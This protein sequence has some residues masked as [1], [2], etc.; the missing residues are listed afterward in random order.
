[1]RRRAE[2]GLEY[3]GR[4]DQQVKIRGF[5]IEPGEVESVLREHPRVR[6]CVVVPR[7][8]APGDLRLVAYVVADGH[9]TERELRTHAREHLPEYMVPAAFVRI[10]SLPLTRHGKV[11][12]GA[13]PAP[14][15]GS[16]PD[17]AF[18]APVTAGEEMVAGIWAEL[19]GV[20]RVGVEDGFFDLGGN[21]VLLVRLQAR[22]SAALGR[23]LSVIDLFRHTTV[24]SQADL[25]AGER[26]AHPGAD[27]REWAAAR[28]RRRMGA[29]G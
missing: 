25:L 15:K 26:S 6:E 4:I 27:V 3:L 19:L 23:D 12:S 22:L 5:R 1:V 28:R 7:E 14:E 29:A 18:V 9:V 11:D 24:R 17:E 13:L 10:G 20:E 2:G 16:G 21:S 8:D